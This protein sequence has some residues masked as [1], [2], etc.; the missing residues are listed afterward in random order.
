MDPLTIVVLGLYA[1]GLVLAV[2][3]Q[4]T[5]REEQP[6]MK[7]AVDLSVLEPEPVTMSGARFDEIVTPDEDQA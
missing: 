6:E 7:P 3:N 4:Q 1:A 5:Y 2:K